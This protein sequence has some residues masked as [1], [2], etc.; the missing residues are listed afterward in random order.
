MVDGTS[1]RHRDSAMCEHHRGVND[2]DVAG[3]QDNGMK[4][5]QKLLIGRM[6][7]LMGALESR[8]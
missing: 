7:G 2:D 4:S 3:K 6:V 1:T 8:M 5:Y